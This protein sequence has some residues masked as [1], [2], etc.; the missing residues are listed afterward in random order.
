MQ[1]QAEAEVVRL[2]AI[3]EERLQD[4]AVKLALEAQLAEERAK[5]EEQARR[6]AE[7]AARAIPDPAEGLPPPTTTIP[8]DPTA[9]PAADLAGDAAGDVPADGS[10]DGVEDIAATEAPRGHDTTDHS[11]ADQRRCVGWHQWWAH[12][13]RRQRE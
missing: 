13:H 11:T 5:L 12:R 4:E 6:E 9:D 3:E 7:A 8:V 1:Q 10:G 2:R